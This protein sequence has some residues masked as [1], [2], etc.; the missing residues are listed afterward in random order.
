MLYLHTSTY[1]GKPLLI[2]QDCSF[3]YVTI[4]C[5]IYP[6]PQRRGGKEESMMRL[7][8]HMQI[9]DIGSLR[10]KNVLNNLGAGEKT[11]QQPPQDAI[12]KT[13]KQS[14]LF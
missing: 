7:G 14:T 4:L 6:Q 9:M 13:N 8:T 11:R 5:F 1:N 10:I 12:N 3:H 2:S